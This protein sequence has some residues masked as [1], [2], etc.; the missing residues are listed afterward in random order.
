MVCPVRSSLSTALVRLTV[1]WIVGGVRL[2]GKGFRAAN[3]QRLCRR[4]D[5]HDM[6]MGWQHQG[7][8]CHVEVSVIWAICTIPIREG[9]LVDRPLASADPFCRLA[10]LLSS[11]YRPDSQTESHYT[12]SRDTLIILIYFLARRGGLVMPLSTV[13]PDARRLVAVH[14]QMG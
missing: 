9:G 10:Y 7:I 3:R 14:W 13:V 5:G 4:T 1:R 11:P 6:A 8:F 12:L 2:T